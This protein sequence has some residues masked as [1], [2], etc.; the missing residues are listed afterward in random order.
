MSKRDCPK[1]VVTYGHLA[2]LTAVLLIIAALAGTYEEIRKT[3]YKAGKHDIYEEYG[4]MSYKEIYN[5]G[6][7]RGCTL[8]KDKYFPSADDPRQDDGFCH[9]LIE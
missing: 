1:D 2:K 9:S 8:T 3:A 7:Y 5:N 4:F 6:V